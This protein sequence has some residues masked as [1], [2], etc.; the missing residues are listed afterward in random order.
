MVGCLTTIH[1]LFSKSTLIWIQVSSPPTY[2]PC[3]SGRADPTATS[4]CSKIVRTDY[5][6]DNP[7]SH[8][9]QAL[10]KTLAHNRHV[11]QFGQMRLEEQFDGS[12]GKDISYTKERI[13]N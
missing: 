1:F 6:K 4:D 2:N 9:W 12:S 5:S 13:V 10:I 8:S 7:L 11:L 3:A